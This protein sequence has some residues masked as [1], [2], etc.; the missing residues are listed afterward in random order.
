VKNEAKESTDVAC[1]VAPKPTI[2]E[3]SKLVSTHVVLET[4]LAAVNESVSPPAV[5]AAVHV[6]PARESTDPSLLVI[7]QDIALLQEIAVGAVACDVAPE[8]HVPLTL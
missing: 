4:Q 1:Q 8:L 7:A 3:P 6:E 2:A 5:D